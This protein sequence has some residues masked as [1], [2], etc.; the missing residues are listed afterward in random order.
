[1]PTHCRHNLTERDLKIQDDG[2]QHHVGGLCGHDVLK[3]YHCK[4]GSI[5]TSAHAIIIA[6]HLIFFTLK[7]G[8]SLR[9]AL[10]VGKTNSPLNSRQSAFLL[11]TKQLPTFL[12]FVHFLVAQRI[13]VGTNPV[14]VFEFWLFG[15]RRA[16]ILRGSK[17]EGFF[18][19]S[20][21]HINVCPLIEAVGYL[22]LYFV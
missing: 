3:K 18:W 2:F 15:S 4:G 11:T 13:S 12:P 9:T 20:S 7:G 22:M 14:H 16:W 10:G 6:Q 17:F 1:M 5:V 8:L 19:I 21:W